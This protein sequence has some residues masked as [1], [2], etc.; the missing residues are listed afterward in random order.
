MCEEGQFTCATH[1]NTQPR[2]P[3]R[4]IGNS[5]FFL[6]NFIFTFDAHSSRRIQ[7]AFAGA[8]AIYFEISSDAR[9]RVVQYVVQCIRILLY[10]VTATGLISTL[11]HNIRAHTKHDMQQIYAVNARGNQIINVNK[12]RGGIIEEK[13]KKIIFIYKRRIEWLGLLLRDDIYHKSIYKCRVQQK[14]ALNKK[15]VNNFAVSTARW[16]VYNLSIVNCIYFDRRN[17]L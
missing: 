2:Q 3:S 16:C 13:K 5:F 17:N 1:S 12:N 9:V 4:F 6:L 14:C 10:S 7:A 15:S 8:A 11:P